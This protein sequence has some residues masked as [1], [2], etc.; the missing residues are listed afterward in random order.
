[1]EQPINSPEIDLTQKT[2]LI[3]EDEEEYI[4]SISI[5]L[6]ILD[7]ETIMARN[8][9]EGLALA[10]SSKPDLIFC[11]VNMPIMNGFSVLTE[12]RK[13][14]ALANT[15][16]IFLTGNAEKQDFRK[17]MEGG[18]DDYLTKP[19][20]AEELINAVNT[21]L[22]KKAT[23][24][25]LIDKK[26]EGIKQSIFNSL[27]HE[28]RTPLNSILGFSSF[29]MS[30]DNLEVSDVKQMASLI[31]T[32]GKRLEHLLNNIVSLA[33]LQITVMDKAKIQELRS[34]R[35][36]DVLSLIEP[37]STSLAKKYNRETDL[38]LDINEFTF[39]MYYDYCKKVLE[40]LI[41]NAFKYSVSGQMVKIS[42]YEKDDNL[43]FLIEDN[44]SGMTIN[45]LNEISAFQQFERQLNE[46]QG[47]GLGLAIVKLIVEI[48]DAQIFFESK[49]GEGTKIFIKFKKVIDDN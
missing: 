46:Q 1:M 14:D 24:V 13:I 17:G 47:A 30:D 22:V 2:I 11:D 9:E 49:F 41:D 31:Y 34:Y 29:I 19:F 38:V 40:E 35:C 6:S 44:G 36:Y 20:T 27:P 23:Q 45:Q 37:L 28:F 32:S 43:V 15:P 42:T 16:F 5:T 21:Q 7:Y 3:I 10:Q 48:F 12:I 4:Q 25:R 33:Q 18:A 39:P 8:G 26:I